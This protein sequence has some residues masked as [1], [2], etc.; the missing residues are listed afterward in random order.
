MNAK[1]ITEAEAANLFTQG[2]QDL[3][4]YFTNL[5]DGSEC[6]FPLPVAACES[7][8]EAT[9]LAACINGGVARHYVL[10]SA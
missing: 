8:S 3:A 1:Q 2:S 6:Y 9:E 4:V 7:L 10:L 5:P